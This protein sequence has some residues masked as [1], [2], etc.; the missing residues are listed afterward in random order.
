MERGGEEEESEKRR[1][2][3]YPLDEVLVIYR[4]APRYTPRLLGLERWRRI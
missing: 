3:G 4:I 2:R 1:K